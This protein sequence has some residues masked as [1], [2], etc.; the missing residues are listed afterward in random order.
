MPEAS[1][2]LGQLLIRSIQVSRQLLAYP[3]PVCL[4]KAHWMLL[5]HE[6]LLVFRDPN[7]RCSY[8]LNIYECVFEMRVL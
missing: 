3:R 4:L 6:P 8:V 1:L 2:M 5:S 7:H